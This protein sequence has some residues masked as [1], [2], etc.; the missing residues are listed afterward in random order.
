MSK[1]IDP[2][3][4]KNSP[5]S[6][7]REM[8]LVSA[9]LPTPLAERLSLIA[10]AQGQSRSMWIV[11]AVA[12]LVGSQRNTKEEIITVLARRV[13]ARWDF[14]VTGK[15]GQKWDR[16]VECKEYLENTR[17]ILKRRGIPS[18]ISEKILQQTGLI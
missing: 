8:T 5:Q 15:V 4:V 13:R 16:D 18:A 11:K 17:Y 9:Y 1:L 2:F 10:L 6:P 12:S 7:G 3:N 14:I